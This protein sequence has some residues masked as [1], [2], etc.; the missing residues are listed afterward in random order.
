MPA[1]VRRLGV[2]G[3]T[4]DP[5]HFAHLAIAE[6]VR[7]ALGLA[8]VAF[9][10]AGQPVHKPPAAVSLAEHRLRMVELAVAGNPHFRVSR[11]EIERGRPSYSVDTMSDLTADQPGSEFYFIVS[12]EAVQGLPEW[13]EPRRLLELCRLTVVP[14]GGYALPS[15]EWL[16]EHFAGQEDR[17]LFVETVHLGHSASD[18]R[19]RVATGRSIRYLVPSEVEAY[20]RE[21]RLYLPHD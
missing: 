11:H 6:Q 15:P 8:S 21:N 19:S 1:D 14:R 12:A 10:P 18:I 9:M 16:S 13:R 4:F 20:I 3:G 17:F 2:L 7:E 5:P